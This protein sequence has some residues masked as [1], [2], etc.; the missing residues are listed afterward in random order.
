MMYTGDLLRDIHDRA[1]H[2]VRGLLA[3][4]R[5]FSAEEIERE[6]PGFG[7]GTMRLQFHHGL[8]A[9]E[10]WIGVIRGAFDAEDHSADYPTIESLEAYRAHVYGVTDAYLRSA[11]PGELS[12][13]RPMRTW[14]GD[15]PALVP[16]HIVLR[17]ITH[18]Y[19]HQGQIAAMCRILGRPIPQGL[20]FPIRAREEWAGLG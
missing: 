16:A 6:I 17:T 13:P 10:Y 5:A 20:D 7:D 3:H 9:A 18:L 12:T 2:S 8:S 4:C 15:Q 14:H 19:H 11:S 1:H